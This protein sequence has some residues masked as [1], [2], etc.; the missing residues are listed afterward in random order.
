MCF[1]CSLWAFHITEY[2]AEILAVEHRHEID[3]AHYQELMEMLKASRKASEE[4]EVWV[5]K[6]KG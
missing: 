1:L 6:E 2:D 3:P 5:E 4:E